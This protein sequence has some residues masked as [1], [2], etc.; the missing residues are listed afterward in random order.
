MKPQS[1]DHGFGNNPHLQED[2]KPDAP[3][4]IKHRSSSQYKDRYNM[5]SS[6]VESL[7]QLPEAT[8]WSNLSDVGE[9]DNMELVDYIDGL[10]IDLQDITDYWIATRLNTVFKG[11]ARIWYTENREIHGIRNWPWWKSQIFQEYRTG[12]LI[13]KKTI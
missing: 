6:D 7:K 8:C 1:Q 4:E 11:H 9:Y 3:V 13:W 10:F 2:I 5:T 12:T